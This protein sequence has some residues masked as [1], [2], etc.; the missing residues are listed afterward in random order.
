[1]EKD[2]HLDKCV[3]TDPD[4]WSWFAVEKRE[5]FT[6]VGKGSKKQCGRVIIQSLSSITQPWGHSVRDPITKSPSQAL[7]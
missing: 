3:S 5:N 6:P 1:M 4:H 7:F 2:A